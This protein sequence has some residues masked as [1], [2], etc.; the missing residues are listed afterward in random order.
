MN[1]V[2]CASGSEVEAEVAVVRGAS[3]FLSMVPE[4]RS[5]VGDAARSE[6]VSRSRL[7]ECIKLCLPLRARKIQ[8]AG[9]F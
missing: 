6:V 7:E 1:R 4:D 2:G 5:R 8:F 3:P 9:V